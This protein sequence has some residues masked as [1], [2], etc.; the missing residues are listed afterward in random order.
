LINEKISLKAIPPLLCHGISFNFVLFSSVFVCFLPEKF[1]HLPES[2]F[3][4]SYF[5]LHADI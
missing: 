4:G 5:F 3:T 1:P 2:S